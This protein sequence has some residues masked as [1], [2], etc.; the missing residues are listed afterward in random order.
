MI[1]DKVWYS[2]KGFKCFIGYKVD[3]KTKTLPIMLLHIVPYIL[4]VLMNLVIYLFWLK[5]KTC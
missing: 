5:M 4:N 2:K 1:S 3:D